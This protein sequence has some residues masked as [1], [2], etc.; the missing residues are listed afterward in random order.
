MSPVRLVLVLGVLYV[1]AQAIGGARYRRL[2][3][4]G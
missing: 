2:T 4:G 3:S 1:V